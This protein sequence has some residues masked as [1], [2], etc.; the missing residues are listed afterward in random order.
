MSKVVIAP[1]PSGVRREEDAKCER[2]KCQFP[3]TIPIHY[4]AQNKND[5][6][7]FS[8]VKPSTYF[9]NL[10]SANDSDLSLHPVII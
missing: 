9:L 8:L 1:A 7:N 3:D 2:S 10:I 6:F 4:L 5:D